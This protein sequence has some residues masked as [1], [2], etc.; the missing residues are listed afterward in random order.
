MPMPL[1]RVAAGFLLVPAILIAQKEPD[2][3]TFRAGVEYVEVDVRVTDGRGNAVRDLT[4]NDFTL[5]EDGKPHQVTSFSFVDLPIEPPAVRSKSVNSVEPD[6]AGN[7]RAG[8]MYVMLLDSFNRVPLRARLVARRFVEEAVGPQDYVAVIDV[9]GKRSAAQGFT[10]RRQLMLAAIDRI[11]GT[12]DGG[13]ADDD[14]DGGGAADLSPDANPGTAAG[15]L[16]DPVLASFAVIEEMSERLG[17]MSGRRKVVLWFDPPSVFHGFDRPQLRFAQ[18]D[19]VRAATRNNVAFYVVSTRGLTTTLG[20][21]SL[22]N[23]SGLRVLA[24]DTAGDVIV[25]SN[26]F[27]GGFERFVRDNSSYYLLG[28]IP[29]VNHRDGKF[30]DIRVRVNRRGLTVR[31]RRGYYAP[32][33]DAPTGGRLTPVP[34]SGVSREIVQALSMPSSTGDLGI[35]L[36]ATPFKGLG[37]DGSVVLGA[38]LRGADLALAV[39]DRIEIAHEAMTPEGTITPGAFHART[40]DL[41]PESRAVVADAGL[42]IVDRLT[43]TRGRHQVRFAVHQRNGKTGSVVADVDIPD[44]TRHPLMLSGVL[45]ASAQTAADPTLLDDGWAKAVLGGDPTT[46]RRF[47]RTD[48]ITAFA[49]VYINGGV[50]PDEVRVTGTLTAG[51]TTVRSEMARRV[52]D[53]GPDRTGYTIRVPL[54]DF[55]PGKYVLMIEARVGEHFARR[56]LPL[57]VE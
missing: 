2:A 49:E 37:R 26:N 52:T 57:A 42:R 22:V 7:A 17:L 34:V 19:A 23:R 14:V 24:E 47:A 29:A 39:G 38:Q 41:T 51:E 31:A 43:L 11:Y 35:D 10:D 5:L 15:Y 36:F 44:F 9:L 56:Q 20:R 28:Y 3:Q 25:D 12:A 6:V 27:S 4:L 32:E 55:A 16:G 40:L 30:H 45:L 33:P 46:R 54:A 48:T 50:N 53:D 18:R 8:R 13:A 21:D 1:P